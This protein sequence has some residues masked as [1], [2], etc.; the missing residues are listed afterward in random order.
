M[1]WH[2]FRYCVTLVLPVFYRKIQARNVQNVTVNGPVLIAM[3]H[4]NAFVD[5]VAFTFVTY[6]VRLKY[7]ARGDAFK[8]GLIATMLETLGIVPIFRIQDGGRE[9]LKKNNEA[10]R[11]VNELLRTNHKIVVF[12]EGLCVQERRLRPLKRGVARMIFGAH[13]FLKNDQLVVVPVGANYS[14]P[15]KIRSTLF[16]NVGEPI[17]L[18]D[19]DAELKENEARAYTRFMQLLEP[20]MKELVIHVNNKEYDE[21]IKQL[22]E[23]LMPAMRREKGYKKNDLAA[24]FEMRKVI[25]AKLNEAEIKNKELVDEFKKESD[26]YFRAVR[27]AGMRDWLFDPINRSK[28]SGASLWSRYFFILLGMPFFIVGL[29]GNFLPYHGTRMIVKKALKANKEFR[30]SV[31]LAVG[32]LLSIINY[33]ALFFIIYA[34]S[35]NILCPILSCLLFHFCGIFA[36]D[37]QFYIKKA[38]GL[39]RALKDP[40]IFKQFSEKREKLLSL[41]NRF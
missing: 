24:D 19:F 9:G 28:I 29:I 8:P 26:D 1:L 22:D 34:F 27:K 41:I 12:A 7:L 18:K 3:N 16:Y 20:K 10:F 17:Y 39:S 36:V 25:T 40:V 21:T 13:D 23:L 11:R 14:Q 33:T 31:G 37:F 30:A 15:D 6:P 5:P 38:A 35:P 32:I 4:P 2:F